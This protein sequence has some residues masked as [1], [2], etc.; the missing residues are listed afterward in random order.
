[1]LS[2]INHRINRSLFFLSQ[3]LTWGIPSCSLHSS[4]TGFGS[5]NAFR[6]FVVSKS[7]KPVT[8]YRGV[9]SLCRGGV[10]GIASTQRAD[11]KTPAVHVHVHS[12]LSRLCFFL[13]LTP[14]RR[15]YIVQNMC[16]Y[17]M[18]THQTSWPLYMNYRCYQITLQVKHFYTNREQCKV[19]TGYLSL[20]CRP[21]CKWAN[22]W[23]WTERFTV[24]FLNRKQ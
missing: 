18:Y 4:V 19:L 14:D 7:R 17:C 1:M 3:R 21:G 8:Q 15:L 11:T 22:R 13:F 23:H 12:L 24:C 5:N 6:S 10:N 16:V 2:N 9:I 20:G